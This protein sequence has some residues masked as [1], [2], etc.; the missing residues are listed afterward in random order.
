MSERKNINRYYPPDVDP[1]KVKF[2]E[3]KSRKGKDGK[4]KA[5]SVRMMAPFSMK[6]LKCNEYI[7]Q[8]RKF[9]ARKEITDRNYLDIKIIKFS[10]RCPKCYGEMTFETDPKNGD[11]QCISGCKKNYEKPKE[12]KNNESIDEMITRLD[13]EVEEDERIKELE[14][15]GG[16]KNGL[17]GEETGMEQLEKRLIEQQ[18]ERERI[19]GLQELQEQ[20]ETLENQRTKLHNQGKFSLNDNNDEILDIEAKEAFNEY[21]K[22]SM[23]S[24]NKEG[25]INGYSDDSDSENDNDSDNKKNLKDNYTQ[26][27]ISTNKRPLNSVKGI[28]KRKKLKIIV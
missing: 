20:M 2:G 4:L 12:V 28:I 19:E 22:S 10:L 7:A 5:Q 3:K 15:K 27:K 8:S 1:S 18:K 17:I 16:K 23:N 6:C 25:L 11:Y 9:N 24:T 13:K 14:R 21:K 26:T